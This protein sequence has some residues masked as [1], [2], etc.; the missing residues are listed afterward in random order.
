MHPALTSHPTRTHPGFHPTKWR[1]YTTTL[2]GPEVGIFKEACKRN[3]VRGPTYPTVTFPLYYEGACSW[4]GRGPH[5][6]AGNKAQG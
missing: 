1:D 4:G 6:R 2:D 3:K 5:Q